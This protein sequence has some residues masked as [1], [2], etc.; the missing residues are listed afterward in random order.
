[1]RREQV[2]YLT[3]VVT[4]EEYDAAVQR[5]PEMCPLYYM[6]D[7]RSGQQ[8]LDDFD[9]DAGVS[10]AAALSPAS[11]APMSDAGRG[12]AGEGGLLAQAAAAVTELAAFLASAEPAGVTYAGWARAVRRCAGTRWCAPLSRHTHVT[13]RL[14]R[15]GRRA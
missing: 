10:V 12:G 15:P 11:P 3:R 8:L 6:G 4:P 1:M 9:S 14:P 7:R 5:W 2:R 13:L